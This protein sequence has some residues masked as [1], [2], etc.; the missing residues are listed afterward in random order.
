[1][2]EVKREKRTFV[3][4]KNVRYILAPSSAL[5]NFLVFKYQD[6]YHFLS[7]L[8]IASKFATIWTYH[9]FYLCRHSISF[10]CRSCWLITMLLH[11]AN[12][13]FLIKINQSF[14]KIGYFWKWRPSRSQIKVRRKTLSTGA[15]KTSLQLTG[16]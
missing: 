10:H 1:M 16:V 6:K 2:Y 5:L 7:I 14:I 13:L 3:L 4:W 12:S 15:Y 11:H 9:F 8:L